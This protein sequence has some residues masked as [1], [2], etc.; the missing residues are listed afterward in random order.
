MFKNRCLSLKKSLNTQT[1]KIVTQCQA[2]LERSRDLPL[3]R[4]RKK[5]KLKNK[6]EQ[7]ALLRQNSRS[8][9]VKIQSDKTLTAQIY[10]FLTTKQMGLAPDEIT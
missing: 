8:N 9:Q 6:Q 5:N 4:P 2:T 7:K 1:T 3:I 10:A